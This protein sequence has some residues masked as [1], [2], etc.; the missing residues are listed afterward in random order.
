MKI[1]VE[2]IG[3]IK[4]A[5]LELGGL[6]VIAGDNNTGK[7]YL[8]YALYGFLDS[9]SP[10]HMSPLR[11][12]NIISDMPATPEISFKKLSHDKTRATLRFSEV[13]KNVDTFMGLACA[14]FSKKEISAV[15]AASPRQF[16]SAKIT[17]PI[18]ERSHIDKNTPPYE[19]EFAGI[20]IRVNYNENI[21]EIDFNK[22]MFPREAKELS[23]MS[24]IIGMVVAESTFMPF[25]LPAERISISLFYKGLDYSSSRIAEEVQRIMEQDE[26]VKE[27]LDNI[28]LLVRRHR[29]NYAKPIAHAIDFMR[30]LDKIQK[31]KSILFDKHLFG[32]IES[33]VGGHYEYE[34]DTVRFVSDKNNG[35]GFNI[36][37]DMT[38]SSVRGLCNL[39]FHLKHKTDANYLVIIDEPE[40]H[41]TPQNQIEMARLIAR[42]VNAG[43]KI[44]ITTHSDYIIKELNNLIMLSHDFEGKD[45]F[46]DVYK[47]HYTKDDYLK[48]DNVKF[49][50]CENGGL[51]PCKI[52]SRGAFVPNFE[53]TIDEINNISNSLNLCLPDEDENDTA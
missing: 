33:M 20:A 47:K 38:S 36:P 18:E 52:T 39:Y 31:D 48:K 6:T 3:P 44:L 26:E 27:K 11:V 16:E 25:V 49:Y 50:L 46:L 37:L 14:E 51:S 24:F 40:S 23:L 8:A 35:A 13:L 4:K 21:M 9:I 10:V 43:I 29:A 15:F 22:N 5:N 28:S 32:F 34:D 42:C 17:I 1:T 19:E 45:S 7:T 12:F 41:L 2:N 30:G 53:K